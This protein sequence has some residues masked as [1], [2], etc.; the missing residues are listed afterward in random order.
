M[1]LNCSL[2]DIIS[3]LGQCSLQGPETLNSFNIKN[4][5]SFESA[6]L[7]DM[8][9]LFDRGDAS[10]FDALSCESISKSKAGL[11][12]ADR[13]FV[14][15]KQ[16]LLVDDVED[17]LLKIAHK[18][19]PY[20]LKRSFERLNDYPCCYISLQALLGEQVSLAP[21]VVVEP[22]AMIGK[23]TTIGS[24]VVIEAGAVIGEHVVIHPQVVIGARCRIG[25]RS[26]IHAGSVIGSDGF[27][28]QVSKT[29][30]KKIPHLGIVKVGCDVEI[31][32]HCAVDR[33][34]F[35]V[36]EIGDGSKLDNLVHL[37]HN[38]IIGPH[39]AILAQ[40]GIAG[41]A[42]IG[43]GCQIGGQ[44]AIKDHVVIGDRAKIVSKS[45]VMHDVVAG[46]VVCGIPAQPFA[47]WKRMVVAMQ[48]L[49]GSRKRG[50]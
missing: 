40:T 33:A 32:A 21:G 35:D 16:Y 31:G 26:I 42:R 1:E 8:A 47:H 41:S 11:F 4:I 13:V 39:T 6:G 25:D 22:E 46:S 7:H 20:R 15:G 34:L 45:A 29:G 3:V 44:V 2:S 5:T 28:Y 23:G 10:V 43:M 27:G 18:V 37:A 19:F 48:K 12:L 24:N 30:L 49:S 36:T 17:A 50:G 14:P 9:V 38:V